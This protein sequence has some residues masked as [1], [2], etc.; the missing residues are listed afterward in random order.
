[1]KR[2]CFFWIIT[3]LVVSH[4]SSQTLFTYGGQ[5][6]DAKEFLRAFNKNNKNP[7]SAKAKAMSDYLGLY[8][9]SKL[10]VREA[11]ERRFDTIPEIKSEMESLRSQVIENY[12]S[13]S[14][15][16]EKLLNEAFQRSQKVIHVA[17]IF[18][19][20]KNSAG[21][22]DSAAAFKKLKNI[23]DKLKQ[24]A[25]FLTLAQQ[26]SED[27]SAKTN[28]GDI[29]F[30]TVFTLPYEFENIIYSTPPGKY[31]TAYRSATGF[32]IFKNLEERKA[33][34]KMKAQQILLS[35]PPGSDETTK[36]QIADR[37]DSLY[38]RIL[39]GDDFGTLATHFSNDYITAV[40]G[41][42]MPEFGVGDYDEVFEKEVWALQKDDSVSKPFKTDHGIHTVKRNSVIPV[43]SNPKDKAYMNELKQR[44]MYDSRGK[45]S[46]N[47]LYK[48]I[49]KT[50]GFEDFSIDK[51]RLWAFADS[52]LDAK[53]MGI[54]ININSRAPLFRISDSTLKA[55]DFITYAMRYRFKS[56]GSGVKPYPKIYDDFTEAVAFQYYRDH[57]EKYNDEFR[58]QMN[59][60]R[61]GNLFFEIMQQQIWNQ[62]QAD[63]AAL[64]DIY[65]K[66][67]TKYTWKPSVD[68][69]IFFC[70]EESLCKTLR[71]QV[72]SKP[73][74]WRE[75]SDLMGDRVLA[76]S[77]RY[78]F[79]QIPSAVKTPFKAGM[80]TTPVINNDDN[81]A[82][83]AYILKVYPLP[84]QRSFE[85]SKGLVINDYQSM[86]DEKWVAELK[87]KYP[88]KVYDDVLKNIS[89]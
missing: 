67:K 16:E 17:H 9:N 41:G 36:K 74:H 4:A 62:S 19:S 84:A 73:S 40:N 87:K 3:C 47:I 22:V 86:L 24:G 37:A 2:I 55:E 8:I 69:V 35:Y 14:Q 27:P 52:M 5:A 23:Q 58:Y 34:G 65:Q 51:K 11:V 83:F 10:K 54:G 28:K 6:V 68:G 13:D 70:A 46:R 76:D 61:E 77:A 42:K 33:F 21:L 56:D 75:Q 63:S 81:T 32:H 15:S 12:M 25:N 78:E 53:P 60:F 59:E 29:G 48:Y 88:V 49:L 80:I 38:K 79:Y 82:S 64:M 44:V 89:K 57:L 85:E 50:V 30:I 1:M 26:E 43:V 7:S 72:K 20:F 18:I 45:T 31:S 71:D 39:A 66:N